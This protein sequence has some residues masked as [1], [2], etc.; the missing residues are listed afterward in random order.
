MDVTAASPTNLSTVPDSGADAL[1]TL[2][3]DAAPAVGAVVESFWAEAARLQVT[4][5]FSLMARV[6]AEPHGLE[7]L[8]PPDEVGDDAFGSL[9]PD[10]WESVDLDDT[11]ASLLRFA[12]QFSLDV[13]ALDD[14]TRVEFLGAWH[15]EAGTLTAAVFVA[16]FWPRLTTALDTLFGPT[17]NGRRHGDA[18]D[19]TTQV[20]TAGGPSI[21]VALDQVVRVVPALGA[22]D[23]VTS[24]LV[25]L[26]GARQH[27]CRLCQSLRSRSALRA[28]ADAV[29]FAA[30][31]DYGTSHLSPLAKACL[32][33][34]DG[35]LWTPGRLDPAVVAALRAVAAP[36]QQVELVLDVTRNALNKVAVALAADAPHVTDG[37]EIYDIGPD[38]ELL[39][40]LGL[41]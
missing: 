25:R 15:A 22:L 33:F 12:R 41:D 1:A 16:D 3:P 21:W 31:D 10:T 26:R 5:L 2:A 36:A 14:P 17:P 8:S 30:V 29:A 35:M 27:N 37:V 32:G 6:C 9:T 34:T 13:A 4:G 28:G 7:P 40:G 38:G 39:Y 23:P 24:E 19:R 11:A 20:A 18:Q